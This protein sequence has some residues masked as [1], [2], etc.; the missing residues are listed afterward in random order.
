MAGSSGQN[1]APNLGGGGGGG[2]YKWAIA[3]SDWT[4]FI[5]R[6]LSATFHKVN[7]ATIHAQCYEGT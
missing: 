4:V 1:S 5:F 6:P 2:G 3:T 7:V